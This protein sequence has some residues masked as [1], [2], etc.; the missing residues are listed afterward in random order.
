MYLGTALAVIIMAISIVLKM[1]PSYWITS[2]TAVEKN[3]SLEANNNLAPML[4]SLKFYGL[5]LCYLIGS[6]LGISAISISSPF[7]QE[8]LNIELK[9]SAITVSVFAVFNAIGRIL[10]GWLTEEINTQKAAII[11]YILMLIG[12]LLMISADEGDALTYLVGFSL[13]WFSFGGWLAIAG[14]ATMIWFGSK[15]Y[16]KNYGII[17]TAYGLGALLGPLA[18]SHL[19]DTLGNYICT[20]YLNAALATVGIIIAVFML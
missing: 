1:P 16:A 17:F 14:T 20:F 2:Q 3:A 18:A 12:S 7:A 13:F 5:W 6:F 4:R 11:S 8:I 10:F 15:N 19:R 9:T